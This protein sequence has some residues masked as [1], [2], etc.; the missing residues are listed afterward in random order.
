MNYRGERLR[1]YLNGKLLE[2][3]ADYHSRSAPYTYSQKEFSVYAGVSRETVRKYQAVIDLALQ[4]AL[5]PK[6]TF[7]KDAKC[8]NLQE[9]VLKLQSQ[10]AK[11]EN[12]YVA[13]RSQ[14]LDIIRALLSNS[15]DVSRLI[16]CH[17]DSLNFG[18]EYHQCVL[19]NSV[20]IDDR[21]AM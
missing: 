5:V 12:M 14:Y 6:W 2:L 17:P 9:R 4:S 19:C 7:D 1:E 15:V 13:I 20:L 8:R 11:A 10:L 16:A 3:I 18:R 21:S